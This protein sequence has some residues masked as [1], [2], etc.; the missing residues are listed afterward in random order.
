[1]VD[2]CFH[3]TECPNRP[4]GEHFYFYHLWCRKFRHLYYCKNCVRNFQTREEMKCCKY[5]GGD[6]IELLPKKTLGI[7]KAI[8]NHKKV[9][10]NWLKKKYMDAI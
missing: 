2:M 3:E 4:H 9:F 8:Q 6:I 1:M 5:C 7:L 10:F